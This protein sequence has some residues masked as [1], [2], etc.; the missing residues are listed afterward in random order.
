MTV[1]HERNTFML[2]RILKVLLVSSEYDLY[3]MEEEGLISD[4]I[5]DDYALLHLTNAPVVTRVS[6]AEE[7]IHLIEKKHFDLVVTGIRVGKKANIYE[8]ATKIKKISPNLPIAL[9]T[10]ETGRL[11]GLS[12]VKC[13]TNIDKTFFWHGDARL[14]L[15]IIK[16]FEDIL[17]AS[18]DC[19]EENARVIILVEDSPQFYST[20]LPLIYTEILEQPRS[21]IAEGT[22]DEE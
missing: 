22:S 4:R 13:L 18:H 5:S 3:I 14:F 10:S 19:L 16:Y 12:K 2:N 9:L 15:A 20:Y 7:A 6:T 21:L 17:N 8:M 11:S 1:T